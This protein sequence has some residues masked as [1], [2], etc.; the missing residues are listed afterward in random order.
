VIKVLK[1]VVVGPLEPYAAGFSTELERQGIR[2]GPRRSRWRWRC[3][4]S[5][6]RV[7]R[8]NV[9]CVGDAMSLPVMSSSGA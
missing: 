6:M 1:S 5:A 3:T 4:L 9:L 2:P 8:H 7:W